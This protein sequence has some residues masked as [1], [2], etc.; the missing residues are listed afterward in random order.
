MKKKS[1]QKLIRLISKFFFLLI[2]TGAINAQTSFKAGDEVLLENLSILKNKRIALITN[3]SAILPTGMHIIDALIAKG[4]NVKKIF[5]PEHGFSNNDTLHGLTVISIY[6]N[7]KTFT[8]DQVNDIDLLIFDIQD[9]S[10]RY[11]T[12]VSTLYITMKSACE[13]NIPFILCDRPM[14]GNQDYV[15]GYMLDSNFSSFVG[16]IP[17]PSIYGMTIGEL[18]TY[19]KFRIGKDFN[20]T[21]LKMEGYSRSTD[22]E[23]LYSKWIDLSPSITSVESGRIYPALVYLEGTNISEGRGTDMPF[24]VF[25]APFCN[26]DE[27]IKKLEQYNFAGVNFLPVEFTPQNNAS[28][29][30]NKLC[31]G[32]R[33]DVSDIKQFEPMELSVAILITLK[34]LYPEFKWR[35]NN[36]IDKLTGNDTLRKM[37]NEGKSYMEIINSYQED[38]NSFKKIR[39][40][41]L[42]Y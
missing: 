31:K 20:F 17:T 5:T 12:Y 6:D 34:E 23:G 13:L 35:D 11:Y 7:N 9:L 10:V 3:K 25:G 14:I 26:S 32:V 15:S 28:K 27:I 4:I 30:N 29:F 41:Y 39:N 8:Y 1:P 36:W 33:I 22:Y 19:L 16:L 24:R 38:I 40:K 37:I 42:L 2:L 18:G 21:V